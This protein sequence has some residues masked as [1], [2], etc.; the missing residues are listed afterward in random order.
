MGLS[1]LPKLWDISLGQKGRTSACIALAQ[2]KQK[3]PSYA[4]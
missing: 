1:C 2:R 3:L 4:R